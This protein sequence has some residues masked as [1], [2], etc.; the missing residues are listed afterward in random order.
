[1]K[2][3]HHKADMKTVDR[4]L[5]AECAK[6]LRVAELIFKKVHDAGDEDKQKCE[7]CHKP[8]FFGS[9]YRILYDRRN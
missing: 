3:G 9:T 4:Y 2:G 6:G 8:C 5:C 1:M 7:F